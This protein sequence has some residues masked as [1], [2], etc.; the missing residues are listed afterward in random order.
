M[1]KFAN[2]V[3]V[4]GLAMGMSAAAMGQAAAGQ[5]TPPATPPAQNS[6]DDNADSKTGIIIE[7]SEL[8]VTYPHGPYHIVFHARGNY[9]P[10]LHWTAGN[11]ALPPGITLDDNGVLH[12]E[13]QRAGE[14]HF[15][16]T[17]RDG[18]QPQQAVQKEF[19]IKVV[20]ALVI[21]WKV[22]AHVNVSRI[23][24]S[25]DVTNATADDMD[26]TFE[27]KAVAEN[28]R[29]TEI[30]YQHFPLKKGTIAM[31][32]PFGETL[33]H[34]TYV[35]RVDVNGE[36]ATRNAIYKQGLQMP[37]LLQVVPGP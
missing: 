5:K 4:C 25:I 1:L 9:V 6:A 32:V 33:P 36:V 23:E 11:G 12:G 7:P 20:D 19:V 30:G 21:A 14:F 10:T 16:V 34:G 13:A 29:A 22:P 24:G 35:V 17:V 3:V 18:D 37:G 31:T 8:P 27:V 26:F 2:F 15:S 28:G